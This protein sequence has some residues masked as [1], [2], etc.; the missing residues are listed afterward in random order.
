MAT[1]VSNRTFHAAEPHATHFMTAASHLLHF[2][3][4]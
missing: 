1:S 3:I 4:S 2:Q